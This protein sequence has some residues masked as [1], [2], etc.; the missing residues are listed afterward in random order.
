MSRSFYRPDPAKAVEKF[1]EVFHQKITDVL[2]RRDRALALIVGGRSK[3]AVPVIDRARKTGANA[4]CCEALATL[5]AMDRNDVKVVNQRAARYQQLLKTAGQD[6]LLPIL[7][8]ILSA[9][10]AGPRKK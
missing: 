5:E 4:A 1:G 6:R 2:L 7:H 3:D 10:M 8:G 9:R